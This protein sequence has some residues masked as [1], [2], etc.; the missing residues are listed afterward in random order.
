VTQS[1]FAL[2]VLALIR[3]AAA[4]AMLDLY[5]RLQRRSIAIVA[6]GL[7]FF[8][9]GPVLLLSVGG[10]EFGMRAVVLQSVAIAL[11]VCGVVD[12]FTHVSTRGIVG[13]AAATALAAAVG[14]AL[15]PNSEAFVDIVF[16]LGLAIIAGIL[17]WKREAFRRT[18]GNSWAWGL[19]IC[20]IAAVMY[21]VHFFAIG[22]SLEAVA[23]DFL[24]ITVSVAIALYLLNLEFNVGYI[25]QGRSEGRYRTLF[26]SAG[27]SIFITTLN[28]EILDVNRVAARRLGY[29]RRQLRRMNL[30]E[31]EH[32]D[33]DGD[34][35]ERLKAIERG[36][37]TVFESVHR[38]RDGTEMPVEIS[39]V[40]FE[41]E[42]HPAVLAI[43][44]D[45]TERKRSEATIVRMAYYDPLTGLANRTL[46]SDRLSIAVAHAHRVKEGL[47]LL[48]IDLDNF[49][50]INDTYGHPVGD[51]LLIAV[52]ERLARLVREGDTVAR[53][54]G[55][56]YTVLLPDVKTR[57]AAA[58]VAWKVL[59]SL[60]TPFDFENARDIQVSASIGIA[61]SECCD[62][63]PDELM[64][65]AD[66]A[67]F[68]AKEVGRSTYQFYDAELNATAVRRYEL[69]NELR[70]AL[71]RH[72]LEIHYQPQIRID[73][74]HIVGAEALLRWKHPSRGN[75]PPSIFVPI[76]EESGLIVQIGRW[77]L[78][79]ACRAAQEWGD[80][81]FGDV[82]VG[83]NLSGR[84]LIDDD[85]HAHIARMLDECRIAPEL[86][87]VEITESVAMEHSGP[88]VETFERIGAM[89]V[90]V[91]IDD[92]GT[93]YSSLD[94]LKQL[95]IHTLKVAQP[96][97]ED[98]ECEQDSA[99]I[100]TAIIV[101]GQQLGLNVIAE[102]VET[103]GQLDML[104]ANECDEMQ[105]FL[106]SPAVT[107]DEF[108]D[109]LAL[110]HA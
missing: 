34:V 17:V 10:S 68:R 6:L 103:A 61:L 58:T 4:F 110:Q 26:E 52:G 12:H 72:E 50:L 27:E 99:A 18:A 63:A 33:E 11:I 101:L 35:A 104:R 51:D 102:G 91:A 75:I 98:L 59:D 56:E 54:G 38:R 37:R 46:F 95:P 9:L 83:V 47:A 1:E 70:R 22:T 109:M 23:N 7:V 76:A 105:G 106:F 100:V 39:A 24:H 69:R 28:G 14:S 60:R 15:F 57:E 5:R 87:E 13:I 66:T 48:F 20:G 81:G 21:G 44:R 30:S 31:V 88:I 41:W 107:K 93:G 86:L 73:D 79:E 32:A 42:G 80:D 89:G 82:R 55:D 53:F 40:T 96:F 25:E 92:F 45:L 77:V 36:G 64:R 16:L 43:I 2:A 67:M 85:I 78:E 3:V 90:R 97:V 8:A 62:L 94:R 49:K 84:Q 74:G 65:N 29:T 108:I 71:Q 19:V